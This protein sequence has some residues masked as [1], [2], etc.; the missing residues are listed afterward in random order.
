MGD[1]G[2]GT[3]FHGADGF[4]V[5]HV[6]LEILALALIHG[7]DLGAVL[8]NHG[9]VFADGVVFLERDAPWIEADMAVV[10]AF[11][12]AVPGEEILDAE[13]V[14]GGFPCGIGQGGDIG[15]RRCDLIAEDGLAQPDGAVD[16]VRGG[17]GA[18]S[19]QDGAMGEQ[20]AEVVFRFQGNGAEFV[21]RH[22]ID[23]VVGG[24]R[25]V[26]H[27]EI[28]IDDIEHAGV[29]AYHFRHEADGFIDHVIADRGAVGLFGASAFAGRDV[30]EE[31][32]EQIAVDGDRPH[33]FE[34]H[35]LHGEIADEAGGPFV[36]EQAPDLLRDDRFVIQFP[37]RGK[38][39]Q[40]A[41]RHAAPEEIGEGGGELVLPGDRFP[42]RHGVQQELGRD[43]HHG[44]RFAHGGLHGPELRRDEIVDPDEAVHL[45]IGGGPAEGAGHEAGENLAD[46]GL[47]IGLAEGGIEQDAR[48]VLR[49]PGAGEGALELDPTDHGAGHFQAPGPVE[50]GVALAQRAVVVEV[51]RGDGHG[52]RLRH[53]V[54]CDT[55]PRGKILDAPG[56][57]EDFGIVRGVA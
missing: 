23:A 12:G 37:L 55:R 21:P 19:D 51:L 26:E 31:T 24:E 38:V 7:P 53:A 20:A 25:L 17:A 11:L 2:G 3:D 49:R 9:L 45:L 6:S 39:K 4:Q 48:V 30:E 1:L 28:G 41:V 56:E 52:V 35:P 40:G 13:G 42:I 54:L 22:A 27:G 50:V 34:A 8:G 15:G 43:Q 32:R 57:L 44:K 47:G 10:A 29:A 18:V 46:I 33:L 36:G 5:F 14:L 16:G